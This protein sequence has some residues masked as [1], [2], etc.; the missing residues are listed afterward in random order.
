MSIDMST[1]FK[2]LPTV[3]KD[4]ADTIRGMAFYKALGGK[5]ISDD[6]VDFIKNSEDGRR[7]LED[8]IDIF[9]LLTDRERLRA[10]PSDTLGYQYITWADKEGIYPEG[11]VEIAQGLGMYSD[12]NNDQDLEF[13]ERRQQVLHD[14]YHLLTG[15]N[16]D[17]GGEMALLTFSAIQEKNTAMQII[18]WLGQIMFLI[19]LRFDLF[20]L[21]NEAKRKARQSPLLITQHWGDLIEQPIDEVRKQLGL[22]PVP[23]YKELW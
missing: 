12:N 23:V 17:T 22:F 10:L 3:L 5:P 20:K 21:R 2:L 8:R 7:M 18:A 14:L 19:R 4:P 13:L 1:A 11:L 16:R 6:L 15:Y 9:P